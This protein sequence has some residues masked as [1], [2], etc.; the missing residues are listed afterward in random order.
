MKT[1]F[2]LFCFISFFFVPIFHWHCQAYD[3]DFAHPKINNKAVEESH[4]D[5]NLKK[6]LGFIDGSSEKIKGKKILEWIIDG[7]REEDEPNWRC[8]RH[9]HDPLKNWEEAGLGNLYY[10]MIYWTQT[11]KADTSYGLYNEYSWCLARTYY[12][13]ALLSGSEASFIKT[14]RSLGQVMHL[15]S[16]AALPAHVRN[17]PHAPSF[18]DAD[19]YEKWVKGYFG[20][21]QGFISA[22]IP[23]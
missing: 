16:D 19:P 2:F 23:K 4:L 18:L 10:S 12:L 20:C 6:N 17:D 1:L 7:G 9:F 22:L 15:L 8:L 5:D 13:N 3:N 14:F 21:G 11:P